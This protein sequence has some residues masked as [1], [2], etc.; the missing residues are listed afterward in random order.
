MSW[1][2]LAIIGVLV[3]AT[4]GGL[5]QGFLRSICSLIGLVLGLLLANW[6]YK[7]L[8]VLFKAVVPVEA[9]DDV[10]AFLLIALAVMAIANFTGGVASRTIKWMGL[11]CLDKIGGAVVGFLQGV[12]LVTVAIIVTVAFFPGQHW[13]DQASLPQ[14]FVLALH[15]NTRMSPN[16]LGDRVRNGL[17]RLE[18]QS[19]RWMHPGN[20]PGD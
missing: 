12:V 7:H 11:G 3:L 1:V 15:L 16:E 5:A 17:D 6:N 8:A 18:H 2:D 9:I 10:V 4:L 19:P 13:L 14:R 20:G